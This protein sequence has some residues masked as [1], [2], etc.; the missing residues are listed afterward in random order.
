MV[1]VCTVFLTRNKNII[2][3]MKK[4]HNTIF[5]KITYILPIAPVM[6]G[7]PLTPGGPVTPRSPSLPGL[8]LC[9][10]RP[11]QLKVMYLKI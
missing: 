10:S 2:V 5:N 11:V 9:P 8:P 4:Y 1:C 6:P 7:S 3:K